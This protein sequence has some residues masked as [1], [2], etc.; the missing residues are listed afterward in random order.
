MVFLMTSAKKARKVTGV[1]KILIFTYCWKIKSHLGAAVNFK[2]VRFYTVPWSM[3]TESRLFNVPTPF[4]YFTNQTR[5]LY[6][7]SVFS[8]F[9]K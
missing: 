7:N 3:F 9:H 6:F 4:F 8:L 1:G 2:W 5:K